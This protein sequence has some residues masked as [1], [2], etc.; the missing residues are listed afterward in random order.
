MKCLQ[1][2]GR[3]P[4]RYA[5]VSDSQALDEAYEYFVNKIP[6]Y[7]L[8]TLAGMQTVLTELARTNPKAGLIKPEDLIDGRY[9]KDLQ[10]N[11]FSDAYYK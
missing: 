4:N 9:V 3:S 2:E 8:P 10:N 6:R 5:R 7:P 11:K 1:S